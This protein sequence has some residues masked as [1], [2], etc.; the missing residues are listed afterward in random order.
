MRD[1]IQ[2]MEYTDK[3]S[4]IRSLFAKETEELRTI[5]ESTTGK[6]D[7]IYI[8]P[9]EGKLLQMIIKL[10][11]VKSIVEIGTLSG[12]SANWMVNA[13]P[14]DGIVYTF[15]HDPTRAELAQANIKDPRIKL[16]KGNALKMLP[17]I[18]NEGPFDMVFIDANKNDYSNY[19]TWAENNIKK[20]GIITADN[21]LLFN[22]VW[23]ENSTE[24]VS[25]AALKSMKEFNLR[26][27]D[28]SKYTSLM[29]PTEE[30]FSIAIKEF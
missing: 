19:L 5:R 17:E 15:E 1:V 8:Y 24:R 22:T 27:A 2:K 4:Y 13:L 12:Y 10:A 7:S 23:D 11:G 21:T 29:M 28:N 14:E 30:G 3:L 26:L 25:E 20:G 9:E 18:E 6:N 16:I